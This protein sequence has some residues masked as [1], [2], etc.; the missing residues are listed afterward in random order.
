MWLSNKKDPLPLVILYC[1][2]LPPPLYCSIVHLVHLVAWYGEHTDSVSISL[3]G[4]DSR[5]LESV[6][7]SGKWT[8]GGSIFL[9]VNQSNDIEKI[10]KIN[11]LTFLMHP[12]GVFYIFWN[13]SS[14]QFTNDSPPPQKKDSESPALLHRKSEEPIL[15]ICEDGDSHYTHETLRQLFTSR[16]FFLPG[17]PYLVQTC[18]RLI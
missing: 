3:S 5:L 8:A 7:M 16:C 6:A 11:F 14:H 10:K 4:Q 9:L 15:T 2:I 12:F 1:A 17:N 13:T 18:S